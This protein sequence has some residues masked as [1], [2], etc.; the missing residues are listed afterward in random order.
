MIESDDQRLE[1]IGY[2]VPKTD[3][4]NGEGIVEDP[5]VNQGL[6]VFI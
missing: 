6:R 2:Q 3:A 1:Y 4:E 5:S